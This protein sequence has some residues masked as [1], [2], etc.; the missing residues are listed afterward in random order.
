M[1]VGSQSVQTKAQVRSTGVGDG[2]GANSPCFLQTRAQLGTWLGNLQ[3]KSPEEVIDSY[4]NTAID[5]LK[6]KSHGFSEQV[7]KHICTCTNAPDSTCSILQP[8]HLHLHSTLMS[9][10]STSP[11]NLSRLTLPN[12]NA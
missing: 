5:E 9:N 10:L 2:D 8:L 11:Q 6:E 1:S 4:F 3:L 12:M 7:S